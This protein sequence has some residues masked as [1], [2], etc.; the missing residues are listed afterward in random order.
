LK[1]AKPALLLYLLGFWLGHHKLFLKW[2]ILDILEEAGSASLLSLTC[3]FF[4]E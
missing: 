1:G 4:E 3:C 2:G